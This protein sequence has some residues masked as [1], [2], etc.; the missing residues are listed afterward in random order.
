MRRG[1]QHLPQLLADAAGQAAWRVAKFLDL[2]G[3]RAGAALVEPGHHQPHKPPE[4]RK[5]KTVPLD[6]GIVLG[7][8]LVEQ[9]AVL[10][11]QEA[12]GDQW[13]DAGEVAI[14]Q[15][16]KPG[17]VHLSA[18]AVEDPHPGPV[19]LRIDWKAAEIDKAVEALRPPR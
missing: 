4:D 12:V 3:Q 6:R 7:V 2:G 1:G 8:A 18:A 17:A 19:L 13:W 9:V 16:R 11:E 5:R 14:G 10:D 15:L